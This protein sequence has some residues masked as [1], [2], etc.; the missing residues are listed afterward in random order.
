MKKIAIFTGLCLVLATQGLAMAQE[1]H[2]KVTGGVGWV[3]PM[4]QDRHAGFTAHDTTPAMGEFQLSQDDGSTL[5][6][7][8][9]CVSFD[10]STQAWFGG[11]ITEATGSFDPTDTREGMG[12]VTKVID[13]GT[14]G[15]NGDEIG[16]QAAANETDAC[17]RV[18]MQSPVNTVPVEN[19][20]LEIH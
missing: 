19:G 16:N 8:V 12:L 2:R 11:E 18:E 10:D 20:N 9:R 15:R 6:Y 5:H 7:V 1:D 14:P 13:G 17:A 3:G 4:G